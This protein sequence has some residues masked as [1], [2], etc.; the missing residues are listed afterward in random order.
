MPAVCQQCYLQSCTPAFSITAAWT[1]L[2]CPWYTVT[3]QD[4]PTGPAALHQVGPALEQ[5]LE[6][7]D[8][9][10]IAAVRDELLQLSERLEQLLQQAGA[11]AEGLQ[12]S[13]LRASAYDAL[14]LA[15][16]CFEQL[17]AVQES[18]QQQ[19]GGAPVPRE[20]LQA[21]EQ[22]LGRMVAVVGD[23]A[24][25]SDLHIFVASKRMNLVK[26]LYGE[27]SEQAAQA[28]ADV[29]AAVQL[30]YGSTSDGCQSMLANA[31]AD[32]LQKVIV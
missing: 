19:E 30:R 18:K 16:V 17:A 22:N 29:Q 13:W 21:Q 12:L 28:A 14:N 25:G 2:Y 24:A 8:T 26:Q 3:W 9:V 27:G 11:A 10:A 5:A 15:N 23:V 20:Q 7:M 32:A 6:R 4:A 1:V 31:A